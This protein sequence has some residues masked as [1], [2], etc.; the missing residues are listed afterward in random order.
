MY[1]IASKIQLF[2]DYREFI[3]ARFAELKTIDPLYSYRVASKEAG[4][5]SPNYFKLLSEKKRN[6]AVESVPKV[7]RGLRLTPEDSKIFAQM[8]KQ[9]T[10]TP[11]VQAWEQLEEK[12]SA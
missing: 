3:A 2:T 11:V 4:F 8:V 9:E 6:I 1:G 10:L 7:C 12:L 5:G